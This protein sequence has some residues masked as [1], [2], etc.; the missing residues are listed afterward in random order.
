MTREVKDAF[1]AQRKYVILEY[2]LATGKV[3]ET[4][5]DF[6]VARSSFDPKIMTIPAQCHL[7]I[8]TIG[9]NSV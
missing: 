8:V 9:R 3:K 1:A 5:R 4:C 7:E 6:G 2:A